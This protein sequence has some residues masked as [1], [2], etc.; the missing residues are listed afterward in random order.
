MK[1]IAIIGNSGSGKSTLAKKLAGLEDSPVLDLDTI[2]WEKEQP[3]QLRPTKD[4]IRD[5]RGFCESSSAWVVEGCYAG[6][7]GVTLEYKPELIFL[8]PGLDQCILNC[9]AR[10]W[11][12]HK[13]ISKAE[14]DKNLSFLLEWVA[15]YYSRGGD[16]SFQRH[17]Q[18]FHEYKG[19][20]QRRIE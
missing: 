10:P 17:E 5:V 16:L 12:P 20:K 6:L 11:E 8:D 13:Y 9:R 14:Q 4:A 7:I 2:A 15:D 18:L 19:A 1:R 3:T